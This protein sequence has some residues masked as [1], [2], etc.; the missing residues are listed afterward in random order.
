MLTTSVRLTEKA[1][2]VERALA[3]EQAVYDK[4]EQHVTDEYRSRTADHSCRWLQH[5]DPSQFSRIF[6]HS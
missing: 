2:L 5:A 1:I 6:R 3:L 4:M